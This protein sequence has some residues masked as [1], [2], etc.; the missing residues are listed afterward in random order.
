MQESAGQ[1][2]SRSGGGNRRQTSGADAALP[3]AAM[4]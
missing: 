3:A 1:L 4:R 2:R